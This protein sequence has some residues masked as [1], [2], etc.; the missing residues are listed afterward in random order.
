MKHIGN[1][2]YAPRSR[3]ARKR[4]G[5]GEGSGH[6]GTSTRGHKGHQSRGNHRYKRNFE[7]GQMPLSR[8]IPKFGFVNVFR[9]EYQVINVGRLDELAR[10]GRIG[11]EVTPET[12]YRV[13]AISNRNVPVKILG[14]GELTVALAVTAQSFSTSA[15]EKILAAGGRCTVSE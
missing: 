12:L 1:L 6:G 5:R 10:E 4:I 2:S 7:G 11:T 15:K 3:K 13:G 8:R 14:D 9:T